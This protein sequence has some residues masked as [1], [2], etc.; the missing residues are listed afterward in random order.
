MANRD[1]RFAGAAALSAAHRM[2]IGERMVGL[3][4]VV[5]DM[6]TRN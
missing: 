3:T 1:Q 6:K 4:L 5:E 2:F